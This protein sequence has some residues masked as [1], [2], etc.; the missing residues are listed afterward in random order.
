MNLK[1][2]VVVFP[3][4]YKKIPHP[5]YVTRCD[6]HYIVCEL[7]IEM[8]LIDECSSIHCDVY[9]VRRWALQIAKERADKLKA[10][11]E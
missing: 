9:Q 2:E 1:K 8:N 3:D 11:R 10:G 7:D 5:Y 4:R 6:E